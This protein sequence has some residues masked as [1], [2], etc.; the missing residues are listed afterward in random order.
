MRDMNATI[1]TLDTFSH[2]DSTNDYLR[3]SRNPET[4]GIVVNAISG[5]RDRGAVIVLLPEEVAQLRAWLDTY[6]EQR[7]AAVSV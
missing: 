4:G 3:F 5:N 7:L 2:T 1:S 6:Y